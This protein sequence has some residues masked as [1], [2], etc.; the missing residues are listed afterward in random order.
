[1]RSSIIIGKKGVGL[2]K[3]PPSPGLSE[4][5][6]K[7]ARTKEE[8]GK[9]SYRSRTRDEYEERRATGRLLSATRTLLSLDEKAGVKVSFPCRHRQPLPPDD[10]QCQS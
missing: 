7:A 6:L 8:T 10:Q 5:I 1:M 9:E 4:R 2:G 3:R